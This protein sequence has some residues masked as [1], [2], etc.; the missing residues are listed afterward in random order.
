MRLTEQRSHV[1]KSILCDRSIVII[2]PFSGSVIEKY[3]RAGY[4]AA[5]HARSD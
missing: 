4:F 2:P 3:C 5:I 1:E